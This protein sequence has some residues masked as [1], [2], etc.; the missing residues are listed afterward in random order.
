MGARPDMVTD[1]AS[2]WENWL[3]NVQSVF[4]KKHPNYQTKSS[5]MFSV[6]DL[7]QIYDDV[8]S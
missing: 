3:G 4:L 1:R 2:D 7:K 5:S 8:K 6:L